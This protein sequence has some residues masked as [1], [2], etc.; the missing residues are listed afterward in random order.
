MLA[1]D[2]TATVPA[3]SYD[4]LVQTADT[5]TLEPDVLEHKFYARDVGWC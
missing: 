3:G 5:N 2:G 1:L 4:D